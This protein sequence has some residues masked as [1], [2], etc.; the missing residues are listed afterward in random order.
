[1]KSRR[2]RAQSAGVEGHT[3]P[4]DLYFGN[5][6]VKCRHGNFANTPDLP[7][8]LCQ[9][10]QRASRV[11]VMTSPILRFPSNEEVP[12]TPPTRQL[13]LS[14][15]LFKGAAP[16]GLTSFFQLPTATAVG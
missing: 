15:S 5:K 3:P 13:G 7:G 12:N 9:E 16:P 10:T 14:S 11:Q 2:D 6:D 4:S 8:V 1:M